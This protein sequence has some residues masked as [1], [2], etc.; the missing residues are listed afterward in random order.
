M[1]VAIHFSNILHKHQHIGIT[2]TKI[3][4]NPTERT[5]GEQY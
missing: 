3:I 2:P 1:A 4:S 5:S